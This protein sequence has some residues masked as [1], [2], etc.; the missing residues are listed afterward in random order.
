MGNVVPIDAMSDEVLVIRDAVSS[1]P[2]GESCR[3]H[4]AVRSLRNSP[5][6][7]GVHERLE[8]L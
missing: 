6:D 2:T 4:W 1:W 3:N 8:P 7:G 5:V